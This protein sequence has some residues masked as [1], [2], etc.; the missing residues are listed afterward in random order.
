MR[1][2][3]HRYRFI[4]WWYVVKFSVKCIKSSQNV[5]IHDRSIPTT[6][7][8]CETIRMSK[9]I[10][11]NHLKTRQYPSGPVITPLNLTTILWHHHYIHTSA[12]TN[13]KYRQYQMTQS[14][15]L[16]HCIRTPINPVMTPL[17]HTPLFSI[18]LTEINPVWLLCW[19]YCHDRSP[20]SLPYTRYDE[21]HTNPINFS[22]KYYIISLNTS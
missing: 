14:W 9:K 5:R 21:K 2:R 17:A 22:F 16:R 19:G 8:L 6:P 1:C 7:R 12:R 18:V 10:I 15:Q 11:S 4:L 13:I 20:P 3:L